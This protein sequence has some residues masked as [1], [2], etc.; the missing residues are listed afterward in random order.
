M[1]NKDMKYD[2][3]AVEKLYQQNLITARQQLACLLVA[4]GREP[5]TTGLTGWVYEQTIRYCLW[6]E[7]LSLG[8]S[9]EVKE[10]VRLYG[11]AKIDLMVGRVA[12]EIKAL[13]S[14]GDDT[15]KY[16]RYRAKVEEK[17]WKYLYL[18]RS[19][20]YDPYRRV[21]VQ[22]FGKE[23]TFFLDTEGDWVRFIREI[24]K[25]L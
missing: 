18:T 22:T 15:E 14:F 19:E 20:T 6:Q 12:I 3:D 24:T 7:L 1:K 23:R 25:L 9:P 21:A 5:N 10:Q 8:L 13:G 4:E 11:R 16:E 17:G 2:E